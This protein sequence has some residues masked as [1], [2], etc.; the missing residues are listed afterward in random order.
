[1]TTINLYQDDQEIKK[2]LAANSKFFS[3]GVFFSLAIVA[4]IF[5]VLIGL[6]VY[7]SQVEKN[8]VKMNN[9]AQKQ[10]N[11]L[12]NLEGLGQVVD[13]QTRLQHIK[14]NLKITDGEVSRIQMVDVLDNFEKD[15]NKNIVVSSLKYD[16]NRKIQVTFESNS[17]SDISR[18][19]MSFKNSDNFK[20]VTLAKISRNEKA[21]SCDVEMFLKQ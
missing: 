15:I 2:R 8:N 7:V 17:Y 10:E 18:Q 21:I 6:K 14:N 4:L 13:V 9:D 20:N 11:D 5:L 3:G 16:E 19:I 1:M 12:I